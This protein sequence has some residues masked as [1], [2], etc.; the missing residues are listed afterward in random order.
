MDKQKSDQ[1]HQLIQWKNQ[2]M[3]KITYG[4]DEKRNDNQKHQ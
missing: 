1:N 2:I 3:I 4:E